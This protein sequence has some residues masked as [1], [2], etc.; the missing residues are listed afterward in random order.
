VA[1]ADLFFLLVFVRYGVVYRSIFSSN[2][3]LFIE[4]NSKRNAEITLD[5]RLS[6]CLLPIAQRS[7]MSL[8]PGDSTI[9]APIESNVSAAANMSK[10]A[11]DN[12]VGAT[13]PTD[14]VRTANDQMF[15][16]LGLP[17]YDQ[18][19][20][21]E[22]AE[23]QFDYQSEEPVEK[24]GKTPRETE[25]STTR[26]PDTT[27]KD[28]DLSPENQERLD[29][30]MIAGADGHEQ[31]N[32]DLAETQR[33]L[34]AQADKYGTNLDGSPKVS[35]MTYQ[36]LEENPATSFYASFADKEIGHAVNREYLEFSRKYQ[37]EF[38]S[39][40]VGYIGTVIGG[41]GERL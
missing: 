6:I 20:G 15:S 29:E 28:M 16:N 35:I 39:K 26:E 12:Q 2:W 11:V 1:F 23:D 22:D 31:S 32:G 17:T 34:Q 18:F 14:I 40:N 38:P 8:P 21:P 41:N 30:L 4:A 25:A 10:I 33:A 24:P 7:Y 19:F 3:T 13:I 36:T 37:T 5:R 9:A 27:D